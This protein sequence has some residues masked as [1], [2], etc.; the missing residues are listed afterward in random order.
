[1][2]AQAAAPSAALFEF[3]TVAA[4]FIRFA[5]GVVL[6]LGV[7]MEGGI[8]A[9]PAQLETDG[10]IAVGAGLVGRQ[11]VRAGG[12][13]GDVEEGDGI[14]SRSGWLPMGIGEGQDTVGGDDAV[15]VEGKL[16]HLVVVP[17]GHRGP[18]SRI[19]RGGIRRRGGGGMGRRKAGRARQSRGGDLESV[20]GDAGAI[21][22]EFVGKE[23]VDDLGEDELDGGVVLEEGNGD[24]G[25][26]GE[27]GGAV[28]GVGE[29]EVG[30][31]EGI[32]FAAFAG[33]GEGSAAEAGLGVGDWFRHGSSLRP[34][35]RSQA[36]RR[37]AMKK[38]HRFRRGLFGN[39]IP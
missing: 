19:G 28:T 11:R 6:R 37:C 34:A 1:M 27:L 24:V 33:G 2:A 8:V 23:A 39:T 30:A 36:V 22:L 12:V 5:E 4:R 29:A 13:G 38:P 14:D 17:R 25:G 20:E 21:E 10:A 16:V 31:V 32:A 15:F 3:G 18:G 26:V 35:S 7:G 9:G